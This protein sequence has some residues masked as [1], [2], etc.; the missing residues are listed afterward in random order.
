MVTPA[1]RSGT[2]LQIAT[3]ILA[4][5]WSSSAAGQA[6]EPGGFH[7]TRPELEASL[8]RLEVAAQSSGYSRQMRQQAT[9]EA[10]L[11]R[12]RLETGDFRVGDRIDLRVRG[13]L[14]LSTTYVVETGQVIRLPDIGE[15][16]LEG[17]LRAELRQ[18]LTEQLGRFIRNPDVTAASMI[19]LGIMGHVNTPG[20][21][22]LPSSMLLE[23]ALMEAGGPARDADLDR[24]R[25][26]RGG[27]T[28]WEGAPLQDALIQ[29]LT[30]DQLSL[31][32]G[33]RIDVPKASSGVFSWSG[34]RAAL[35][36]VPALVY[37]VRLLGL[38]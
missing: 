21:M 25:I 13:Q 15:I 5:A 24:I 30:L 11:V 31:R 3:I 26:E 32:A 8:E 7:V 35:L 34:L 33:D 1:R 27:E 22:V 18:H 28:V 14:A 12:S 16:S 37:A 10:A 2:Y 23:D 29:G 20:F 17:V 38:F 4:L 6:V 36:T 19:R 9:R